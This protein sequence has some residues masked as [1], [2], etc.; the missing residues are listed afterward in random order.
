MLVVRTQHEMV[1][2]TNS[3]NEQESKS[4][5]TNRILASTEGHSFAS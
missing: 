1:T 4:I 3:V 5:G 2:P